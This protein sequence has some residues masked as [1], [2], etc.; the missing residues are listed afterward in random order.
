MG[1]VDVDLMEIV[2]AIREGA[3]SLVAMRYIIGE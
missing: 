3:P 2:E 1:D